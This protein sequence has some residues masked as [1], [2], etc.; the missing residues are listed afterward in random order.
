M[1][2]HAVSFKVKLLG[3]I[4]TTVAVVILAMTAINQSL[5]GDSLAVLGRASLHSFGKSVEAMM[6]MQQR[7]LQEKAHTDTGVV[8]REVN[9]K[10]FPSLNKMNTARVAVQHEDGTKTTVELP[11]I[12]LGPVTLT[13]NHEFF[14]P[15][16]E[17]VGGHVSL[18]QFVDGG[19]VLVASTIPG[20]APGRDALI[21]KDSPL[22]QALAKGEEYYQ[23]ASIAGQ[24]LFNGYAPLMDFYGV[25]L[26]VVVAS[27]PIITPDFEKSIQALNVGGKGESFLFDAD[28]LLV[29]H[30]TRAGDTLAAASY[31]SGFKST[32]DGFVEYKD[33][34]EPRVAFLR[35]YAPW[36]LTYGFSLS[37]SE[38]SHGVD[39]T[40]R[41]AGLLIAAGAILLTGLVV[42]VLVN[43]VV[44]PLKRIEAYAAQVA[45]GDLTARLEG[46]YPGELGHVQRSIEQMVARLKDRLGFSQGVLSG[47]AAALPCMTL[48][49]VGNITFANKLLLDILEKRGTPEDY[50]GRHA[51]DFF[52][53]EPGRRIRTVQAMEEDRTLQ[54]EMEVRAPSGELKVMQVNANPIKDLDGVLI[55]AFTIYHDLTTIRRQE[56]EIRSQNDTILTAAERANTIADAIASAAVQLSQQVGATSQGAS[57]QRE[58]I[59]DTADQLDKMA[60][61]SN[62]VAQNAAGAADEASQA[63]SQAQEGRRTVSEAVAAMTRIREQM[64]GLDQSMATLG[65][66]A[67]DIGR[68]ITVIQD[69]AD[70]TNL[71]ALNAAIEAAR[72]G[73][74]GRGFAVV[75]DEVRKLAEKTMTATREVGQTVR[76]IQDSARS[77][78]SA[79]H[80]VLVAVEDGATLA[81]SSGQTLERIVAVVSQTAGK[82]LDIAQAG[83][84]QASVSVAVSMAMEDVSGISAE[85]AQGM[86]AADQAVTQL[87]DQAAAL[88]IIMASLQQSKSACVTLLQN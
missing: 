7:L 73:D 30:P 56:R 32:K 28:G 72:A 9:S 5:V 38:M 70:Q 69:I 65:A 87:S 29:S 67:Q 2:L 40:L 19:M 45:E 26:G 74:A 46:K 25:P 8:L 48:D 55:G 63:Q 64:Q 4:L 59:A 76:A 62:Q 44:K 17:A 39:V 37:E 12:D 6:E 71:L 82:V 18:Y 78:G 66:K 52:Y 60:N 79:T 14:G 3:G 42:W 86:R 16:R 61:M 43:S 80:Q 51:G 21:P 13:G 11:T 68:I 58:R 31:W 27:R 88:K 84:E 75:A 47:I 10:G 36:Q 35:Y 50:I 24:L 41:N 20:A 54:G 33:A 23:V 77:T 53:G 15:I 57:H 83:Q 85:T 81:A 49:P 22:A 34:G 1:S